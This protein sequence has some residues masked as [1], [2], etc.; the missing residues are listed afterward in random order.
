MPHK[1]ALALLSLVV[2][3]YT[4]YLIVRKKP[5]PQ[6]LPEKGLR[7]RFLLATAVCMSMLGAGCGSPELV[8][9]CYHPGPRPRG[10]D[11]DTSAVAGDNLADDRISF[12]DLR[13][14]IQAT[15]VSLDPESIER[16]DSLV[17]DAVERRMFDEATGESLMDA[18]GRLAVVPNFEHLA[19][20]AKQR[21]GQINTTCYYGGPPP[22]TSASAEAAHLGGRI[23]IIREMRTKG[24][25]SPEVLQR[26][27]ID[28]ARELIVLRLRQDIDEAWPKTDLPDAMRRQLQNNLSED[29]WRPQPDESAIRAA[30][31]IIEME[32]SDE[33]RHGLP[34]S[35]PA[36]SVGLTPG[37]LRH[38]Q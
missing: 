2:L 21:D 25:L 22:L 32:T 26:A 27:E 14:A 28:I 1:L 16:F 10:L 33:F 3:C 17:E 8:Q 30:R 35:S 34:A 12:A 13:S 9:S 5:I 36:A 23:A 15:W 19:Y 18:Y 37:H 4:I 7:R 24:T 29:R 6:P 20:Y 31:L 38:P 11:S